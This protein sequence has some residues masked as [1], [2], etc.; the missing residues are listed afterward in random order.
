MKGWDKGFNTLVSEV[1][2]QP[3]ARWI[4]WNVYETMQGTIAKLP[5]AS[6]VEG[7]W[8]FDGQFYIPPKVLLIERNE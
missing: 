7:M 2:L 4:I 6:K 3:N 5:F 1:T 8:R